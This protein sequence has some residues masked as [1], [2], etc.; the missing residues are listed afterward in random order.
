[1]ISDK[2]KELR[3]VG[4]IFIYVCINAAITGGI[5]VMVAGELYEKYIS[6]LDTCQ[7]FTDMKNLMTTMKMELCTR[8]SEQTI[9]NIGH[10]TIR[11]I[12]K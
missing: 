5:N 1:M 4:V 3:N 7:D 2:L 9:I 8:V 10:P 6:L 11:K 12:K